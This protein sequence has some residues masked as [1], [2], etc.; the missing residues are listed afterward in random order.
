MT[1]FYNRV[2]FIPTAGGTADF[3]VR[4]AAPGARTPDQASVTPGAL[5]SY[6]AVGFD[7]TQWECGQGIYSGGVL[8][9]RTLRASSTGSF[10][11]FTNAPTVQFDFH[12]ED[13]ATHEFSLGL[14]GSS[15]TNAIVRWGT[16]TADTLANSNVTIDNTGNIGLPA[17]TAL[18]WA[19]G[20]YT[21]TNSG[22]TLKSSG[23]ITPAASGGAALGASALPWSDLFL[24]SA[25]TV[26]FGNGNY[27]LTHSSG[28]LLAS[29]TFSVGDANF[30]LNLNTAT[31]LVQFDSGDSLG[32][33]RASNTFQWTVASSNTL[34]LS[35]TVLAPAANDGIAL[36]AGTTAFSD[37]FL[38]S[39]GV[40]NFNNGNYTITHTAG[41]LTTN[42][43]LSIGTGNVFTCGTIELGAASDTTLSRVSA[44]VIQVE[45]VQIDTS[46]DWATASN[47]RAATASKILTSDVVWSAADLVTLTDAGT[48]AVDFS[49][50]FNFTV[51]LGGNRTLGNPS[52]TKNGQT[53]VIYIVQDGTGSRTL[54]YSGNWKFAGGTAPVLTTTASAV[55]ML[56]YHVRSSTFI[57]GTLVKDVK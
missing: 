7:L 52:N 37:L 36:G 43:A 6:T 47:Y 8:T 40:I 25:G 28:N 12:A 24:K 39:G 27:T 4:A 42:G 48:V 15:T 2:V 53:G 38:A 14:P 32:Y 26:N 10:V 22:T 46:S 34:T 9:R 18:N 11:N 57:Y 3:T 31:P 13:I 21:L 44:G 23:A 49:A 19:S 1:V 51:T 41:L 33:I 17:S 35:T 30:T 16:S 5:V 54:A 29:G 55:D 45:G 20:T 56:F 50:G